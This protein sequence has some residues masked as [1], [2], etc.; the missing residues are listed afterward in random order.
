MSLKKSLYLLAVPT[1][2]LAACGQDQ[3]EQELQNESQVL[4]TDEQVEAGDT[5]S[6]VQNR[7]EVEKEYVIDPDVFSV[8]PIEGTVD[9]EL[10]LTFDDTPNPHHPEGNTMRIANSLKEAGAGAIFFVN[11]M[12]LEDE[13]SRQIIKDL[14]DMG[15]EIGNHTETHPKLTELSPEQQYDEIMATSDKIE[16]ITGERPR[17]FRPP[18]GLIT[19]YALELCE[20]ED[21]QFT[22]WSYGYDWMPEYHEPAALT[23]ISLQTELLA[24]GANILMHDFEWTADALDDILAGYQEQG[25]DF[26]DPKAI[27]T[28]NSDASNSP[29]TTQEG[30]SNVE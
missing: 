23:E 22:N 20:Q 18:H 29:N 16:E 26:V 5:G 17:F 13:N 15:F 7:A 9:N 10:L 19:D 11:G 27:Q 6:D 1:L 21:M 3:A 28:S 12:Y 8:Q 30:E 4:S 2:L 25:F 24:P 14:Y